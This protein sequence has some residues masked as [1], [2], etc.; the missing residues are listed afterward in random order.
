MMCD[1][2]HTNLKLCLKCLGLCWAS[3]PERLGTVTPDCCLSLLPVKVILNFFFF[4]Y[5]YRKCIYCMPR[6]LSKRLESGVAH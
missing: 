1:I 2:F 5:E 6:P 3:A 4:R